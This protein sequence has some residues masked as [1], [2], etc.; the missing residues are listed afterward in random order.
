M[1]I[2]RYFVVLFIALSIITV[3]A[4]KTGQNQSREIADENERT[5]RP[6][7]DIYKDDF[8][9]GNII[10]TTY[11]SAQYLE[12]LTTHYNTMTCENAMKPDALAPTS[13][14]ANNDW[15]YNFTAADGMVEKMQEYGIPVHGHTLV[16]HRQTPS[17]LTTG[18]K[19][20]V[21]ANLEKYITDVI[22]H[23]EGRVL[24]WDVVNEA[25]RGDFA[26]SEPAP[27]G[28]K[29]EYLRRDSPWY[30]ALGDDYIEIA[31]RAARE[32]AG[33]D[34]KLYYNDYGMHVRNKGIAVYNMIKDINERY[35]A[36]NNGK[37]LIDGMGMQGHWG[38]YIPEETRIAGITYFDNVKFAM[39]NFIDLGIIVDISELDVIAGTDEEGTGRN[40]VMSEADAGKQAEVY[41]I[42]FRLFLE[43]KEQIGRVTMWGMDDRNSWKSRG[44]PCL[45]DGDL[46]AKKA[47]YAVSNPD[48]F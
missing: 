28:W 24:S 33:P 23:F 9:I 34:V 22:K 41:A 21:Q 48:L 18:T 29:G 25:V 13:K 8:L 45:F 14:P 43:N 1:F 6:L 4:C 15:Q 31:F 26:S 47:F 35:A 10:N 19:E 2:K 7:K 44:N 12:L 17:W 27:T 30:R 39:E 5:E 20:E 32:A 46:N 40:S 37:K 11:M 3:T 16:W 38:L 36:E 42:L